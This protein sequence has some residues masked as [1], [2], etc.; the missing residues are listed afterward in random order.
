MDVIGVCRDFLGFVGFDVIA[1]ENS[2]SLK[3]VES[4]Y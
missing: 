1:K 2:H 3:R 4:D